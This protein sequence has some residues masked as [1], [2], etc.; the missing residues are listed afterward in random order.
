MPHRGHTRGLA[1]VL[2]ISDAVNGCWRGPNRIGH[3]ST[4]KA[5]HTVTS[6]PGSLWDARSQPREQAGRD[7]L[8]RR[9]GARGPVAM[10][11][12]R[13]QPEVSL[14]SVRTLLVGSPRCPVCQRVALHGRQEVLCSAACRRVR[15]RQRQAARLAERDAELRRLLESALRMLDDRRTS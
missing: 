10:S 5:P 2:G 3:N 4:G 11:R 12:V 6:S 13:S 9:P 8:S 14:E 7:H 1:Y 15:S